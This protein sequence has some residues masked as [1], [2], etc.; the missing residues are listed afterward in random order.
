MNAARLPSIDAPGTSAGAGFV[1][2]LARRFNPRTLAVGIL[3]IAALAIVG[4][5]GLE[6]LVWFSPPKI[7]MGRFVE[8]AVAGIVILVAVLVADELTERGAPRAPT[9]A[10]AVIAAAI[11]G[12]IAGVQV[13]D[14]IGLGAARLALA[15]PAE[16]ADHRIAYQLALTIVCGLVGGLATFVLVSRRTALAARG[17]QLE[18]ERARALARRRTL[19]SELQALQA[20]VEPMFLFDTLER[21]RATYRSDAAAGSAMMEDLILYLRAALPHLRE[22]TS[23]VAQ[24]F[25]LVGAWLDI[26]GRGATQWVVDLD[27]DDSAREARLPALVLLPLVQCAVAGAASAPM[28]LRLRVQAGAGRLSVD[29]STSRDIFSRGIAAEPR[30]QQIDDRLRALY[31]EEASFACRD[32]SVGPGSQARIELPLDLGTPETKAT[33]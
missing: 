8:S 1:R 28:S 5:I 16:N 6:Y 13:R 10:F 18:A 31:G 15:P 26:V 2:A 30:L 17:R 24:E 20:R 21:I 4:G 25:R 23:T 32:A 19:E 27:T 9:Y 14:E 3:I 22:S 29:L 11:I 12:G 7:R 33:S